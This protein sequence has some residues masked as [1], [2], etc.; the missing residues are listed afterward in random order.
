MYESLITIEP[1]MPN[2]EKRTEII[3]I[4]PSHTSK[5]TQGP[6]FPMLF[7]ILGALISGVEFLY[8]GLTWKDFEGQMAHLEAESRDN[9]G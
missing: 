7:P 5:D 3:K 9:K 6:L 4:Q 2:L 8:L 1:K